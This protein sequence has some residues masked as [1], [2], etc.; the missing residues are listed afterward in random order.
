MSQSLEIGG[1]VAEAVQEI[2]DATSSNDW[3]AFFCSMAMVTHTM[4]FLPSPNAPS[5][6]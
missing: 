1:D 6:N 2:K 3:Y 5:A 4:I